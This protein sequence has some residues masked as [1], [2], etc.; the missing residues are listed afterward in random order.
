MKEITLKVGNIWSLLTAIVITAMLCG[1]AI[2]ISMQVNKTQWDISQNQANAT[3][4]SADK[5][6]N[7]L[8]E[9]GKG[10][11]RSGNTSVYSTC[12]F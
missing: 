11:C 2:Y 8:D 12:G 5:I 7:G 6:S 3:K 10:V 4:E 1:S 9:L